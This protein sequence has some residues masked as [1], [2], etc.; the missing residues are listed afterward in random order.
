MAVPSGWWVFLYLAIMLLS[1]DSAAAQ[2]PTS[3]PAGQLS[4]SEA[5]KILESQG[6][7]V[8]VL[9]ARESVDDLRLVPLQEL[10]A[11]PADEFWQR[12]ADVS[13]ASVESVTYEVTVS[14]EDLRN[15]QFIADVQSRGKQK[16][17]LDWSSSNLAIASIS[18]RSIEEVPVETTEPLNTPER[19]LARWGTAPD[20]RVLVLVDD[21]HVELTGR[22]SSHGK[23]LGGSSG[24]TSDAPSLQP[25]LPLVRQF[26]LRLPPAL[27]ST[28]KLRVPAGR[29]L[30]ASAGLLSGP[31][32]T[33]TPEWVLWTLDLGRRQDVRLTVDSPAAATEGMARGRVENAYSARSDGLHIQLDVGFK[34]YGGNISIL[35]LQI[36]P[37]VELQDAT[38]NRIPVPIQ[39]DSNRPNWARIDLGSGVSEQFCQLRITAHMPV[40]WGKPLTLP[41]LE[42]PEVSVVSEKLTLFAETPLV[43]HGLVPTNLVQ[44]GFTTDVIGELWT[45]QDTGAEPE[46]ELLIDRPVV[47]YKTRLEAVVA[48]QDS[49][50]A[51]VCRLNLQSQFGTGYEVQLQIPSDWQ[52]LDIRPDQPDSQQIVWVETSGKI[53]RK[54]SLEFNRAIPLDHSE[55]VWITLHGPTSHANAPLT[56]PQIQI[57]SAGEHAA[58]CWF[59]L[60]KGTVAEPVAEVTADYE[61][62]AGLPPEDLWRTMQGQGLAVDRG[63]IETTL[64]RWNRPNT[65]PGEVRLLNNEGPTSMEEGLIGSSAL[66]APSNTADSSGNL[67]PVMS[68]DLITSVD[69]S[70]SGQHLQHARLDFSREIYPQQLNLTL[71]ESCSVSAVAINGEHV[72][73]LRRGMRISFPENTAATR[74]LELTYA[75]AE[76]AGALWQD[77]EFPLPKSSLQIR[78]FK[79]SIQLREQQGFEILTESDTVMT[80]QLRTPLHIR[81]LGPLA[82][83]SHDSRFNPFDKSQWDTLWGSVTNNAGTEVQQFVMVGESVPNQLAI[84]YWNLPRLKAVAWSLVFACAWIGIAIR[85][86]SRGPLAYIVFPWFV[87]LGWLAL[88]LPDTTAMLAGSALVGT[89]LSQLV[90]RRF[91]RSET[92]SQAVE[93][94]LQQSSLM[95]PAVVVSSG[96]LFAVVACWGSSSS[97]QGVISAT[98]VKQ[99]WLF[100][101]ANG[102]IAAGIPAALPSQPSLLPDYFLSEA[103]YEFRDVSSA[104]IHGKFQVQVL[105]AADPLV[106]RLPLA[107]V[108]LPNRNA[109]VI[110]GQPGELIPSTTGDSMLI[111]LTGAQPGSRHNIGIDFSMRPGISGDLTAVIPKVPSASA[112]FQVDVEPPDLL[113]EGATRKNPAGL[114]VIQLGAVNR[115]TWPDSAAPRK[116]PIIDAQSSVLVE[117]VQTSVTS[118]ISITGS[119]NGIS[120]TDF[121]LPVGT[122]VKKVQ[123]PHLVESLV[124]ESPRSNWLH[125]ETSQPSTSLQVDFEVP[126]RLLP[127]G[128]IE[129]P[130]L[131]NVRGQN[132]PNRAVVTTTPFL[133]LESLQD[134]QGNALPSVTGDTANVAGENKR[135]VILGAQSLM[136]RLTAIPRSLS[137][138]ITDSCQVDRA[139]IKYAAQV[140]LNPGPMP[141]FMHQ[142]E[143][144]AEWRIRDVRVEQHG[145]IR[146]VRWNQKGSVCSLFLSDITSGP[147]TVLLEAMRPHSPE[148]WVELPKISVR[149]GDILQRQL[150]V[151]D[152]TN[153]SVQVETAAGAILSTVPM[154]AAESK[155]SKQLLFQITDEFAPERLRL[156]PDASAARVDSVTQLSQIDEQTWQCSQQI[157]VLALE[158]K[159]HRVGLNVPSD[160]VER[161]VINPP[162][163]K[164]VDETQP[165]SACA[166]TLLVPQRMRDTATISLTWTISDDE[167]KSQG[168]RMC[169][170]TSA[171]PASQ[172]LLLPMEAELQVRSEGGRVVSGTSLPAWIPPRWIQAVRAQEAACYQLT[173]PDVR[174]ESHAHR[175]GQGHI[176]WAEMLLWL[177]ADGTSQGQLRFWGTC[178]REFSTNLVLTEGMALQDVQ[179]LSGGTVEVAQADANSHELNIRQT[180]GVFDVVIHWRNSRPVGALVSLPQLR[181]V[182]PERMLLAIRQG[183]NGTAIPGN[184]LQAVPHGSVPLE[185]FA[186]YLEVLDGTANSLPVSSSIL[187]RMRQSRDMFEGDRQLTDIQLTRRQALLDRWRQLER[188]LPVSAAKSGS[189]TGVPYQLDQLLELDQ[190]ALL[191]GLT[192]GNCRDVEIRPQKHGVWPVQQLGFCAALFL[193]VV[194]AAYCRF[195]GLGEWLAIHPAVT[196]SLLGTFW[197][198]WL[199]PS[200]L[201][202][203]LLIGGIVWLIATGYSGIG[204]ADKT[205]APT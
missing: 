31:V 197:W 169:E 200:M 118:N 53:G 174:L 182:T 159:L 170:V 194:T 99:V 88:F 81:L 77:L 12:Q 119:G 3:K 186:G 177:N 74:N 195:R 69:P 181:P 76:P 97:A 126:N 202:G 4:L 163:V 112:T 43:V 191:W 20:G 104:T 117:A 132:V 185:Q 73:V 90:P 130:S 106:I 172:L 205:A 111:P 19:T 154:K 67:E 10:M 44:T 5:Q 7:Q 21:E 25:A 188:Q 178:P 145:V 93:E 30:Q 133:L 52:V 11:T 65:P 155:A 49:M 149:A 94:Q 84:R 57:D 113:R 50:S 127:N 28:L 38:V 62:N 160:L 116:P 137:V 35:D 141:W 54:I 166:M 14:G 83:G 108:A 179:A 138:E 15:G 40:A 199:S 16:S 64:F 24:S 45:F 23:T 68:L 36:P 190:S 131:I 109:C 148:V 72:T 156:M 176:P 107:Q 135:T 115:L 33:E 95:N 85:R 189:D 124:I 79:W 151:E 171:Q 103:E 114:Q 60:P 9:P 6:Y 55:V 98:P 37:N 187:Q 17:V 63:P 61:Q 70:H 75:V 175:L 150:I 42:I 157:H 153:W 161:L 105:Q 147:R 48:V 71:P 32:M 192:D 139:E 196:V 168:L 58:T 140:E 129:I 136:A 122:D 51:A 56:F 29:R 34:A 204:L 121:L 8:Q 26:N 102:S 22:W 165:E 143:L 183:V 46:L 158:A 39:F 146:P 87:L 123:G 27:Q 18:T 66:A 59:I 134:S 86:W 1:I 152:L 101:D 78:G 180:D 184:A 173:S 144:Q 142:V 167:L 110:D 2:E 96:I 80:E 193:V 89:L 92:A 203:L 162:L 201:G 100:H 164:S 41:R 47:E 82:R 198:L 120:S 91:V 128:L 125:V 13:F